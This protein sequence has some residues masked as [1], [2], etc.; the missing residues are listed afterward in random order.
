MSESPITIVLIEDDS[1]IRR[2]VHA[3]VQSTDIHV[4]DAEYGLARPGIGGERE[5]GPR[6]RRSWP[7]R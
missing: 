5:A 4:L 3:S 2:F 7:C 1:H 6:H